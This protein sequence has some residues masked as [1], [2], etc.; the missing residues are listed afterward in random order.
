MYNGGWLLDTVQPQYLNKVNI[1]FIKQW[2]CSMLG[3][4]YMQFNLNIAY[5]G[6]NNTMDM[7][8]A[9][10]FLDTVQP[11]YLIHWFHKNHGYVQWRIIVRYS[12]TLIYLHSF[13][14]KMILQVPWALFLCMYET[15]IFLSM[16][17]SLKQSMNHI[18]KVYRSKF[19]Y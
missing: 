8:N 12:S 1:D 4:C 14:N 9:W 11:Q 15:I 7:Y 10:L 16:Y 6:F 19:K 18:V 5:I 13:L 3:Q 2:I 17:I